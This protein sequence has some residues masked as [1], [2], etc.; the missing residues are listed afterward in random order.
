MHVV[1]VLQTRALHALHPGSSEFTP[2]HVQAL[3]RQFEQHAPFASFECLTDV[4]VPGVDCKPL[5]HN[6][7]GWWSKM[8]LFSPSMKGDFLFVDLDTV[9]VGSLDDLAK[10]NKL[11]LLRDFYR[12]GKKLKEGLGGGLCFLPEVDRAVVWDYWIKNP[13]LAMRMAGHKGD[14]AVFEQFYRNTADR[15]QD[16]LPGQIVSH[17]VHCQHGVPPEARV[18]CFHGKPRPWEVGQHLHLYR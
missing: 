6:W 12:D 18:I 9:I 2:A 4:N 10:A 3:Q 8:N 16:V 7:P 13:L 11:T 17:K 5:E 14:M 15:W 1:T